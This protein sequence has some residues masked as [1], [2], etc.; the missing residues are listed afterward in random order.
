MSPKKHLRG[1]VPVIVSLIVLGSFQNCSDYGQFATFNA[2]DLA[3][4]SMGSALDQ[5]S[6]LSHSGVDH[7]VPTTQAAE[8]EYSPVVM[9]RIAVVNFFDDV[10]GPGARNL[11]AVKSI[12][13]DVNI[14]GGGCSLYRQSTT[15]PTDLT[16]YCANSA[17]ALSVKPLMSVTVLRQGRI[18]QACYELSQN[19]TTLKYILARVDAKNAIPPV[20]EANLKNL[21]NLFYRA[22]PAPSLSLLE[23]MAVNMGE[24]TMNGWKRGVYAICVSGH[25]QV[26]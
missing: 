5:E 21:F 15:A 16:T 12:A 19:A 24:A 23:A 20:T 6:H 22:K 7:V 4:S 11:A 14:F 13:R 3:S 8:I 17:A 25:W 10:F 18:N 9:D 26:L 1:A 2:L